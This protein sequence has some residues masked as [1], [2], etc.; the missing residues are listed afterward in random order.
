MD[1]LNTSVFHL[2]CFK[3]A[4]ESVASREKRMDKSIYVSSTSVNHAIST[5]ISRE[6]SELSGGNECGIT[7]VAGDH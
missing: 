6:L 1:R 3:V 2:S 5:L 4:N 7:G